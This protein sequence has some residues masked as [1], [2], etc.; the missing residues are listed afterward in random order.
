[1]RRD[2][3]HGYI[4][5][6]PE[7]QRYKSSTTK[8]MGPLHPLPIPDGRG[9]SVAMDFVGPLPEDEG[10]NCILTIT[11][12]LHSDIRIVP[13]RTDLTAPQLAELFFE[14]WYCE[15]GLPADIVCDRDRLFVS[16]FWRHLTKLLGIKI[17]MSTAYHLQTDGSS[18][19]SNKTVIQA[20]RFHVDRSQ[21]NWVR[22][23]RRVRFDIMN[24]VN[25]STGFLPFQLRMGHSPRVVPPLIP[26]VEPPQSE[27]DVARK[28]I[29]RLAVDTA[30]AQD[31]MWQAKVQQAV[32]ANKSRSDDCNFQIGDKVLVC[33]KD[34]QRM[35]KRR[36]H[37][38]V[39]K[40]MPRYDGPFVVTAVHPES[41]NVTV[42]RPNA[43][44]A[45]SQYHTSKLMFFSE[46]DA[47]LF[48]SREF[49]ELGPVFAPDTGLQEH[50]VEKIVDARR[51]GKGW[52]YLV[53]FRGYGPEHDEWKSGQELSN[54]Q[55]L[56]VWLAGEGK[57]ST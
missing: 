19:R 15:N 46:N 21:K 12:R 41:S 26:A 14:H 29:E 31:N 37:K 27:E 4:P 32:Q 13:T 52:Q 48:P 47:R 43:P 34:T 23:L 50:Y 33:T 3:E 20:L 2:L 9:E 53:R 5:A 11:D 22:A 36:G 6:C 39:A 49:D 10:Y 16:R 54:N 24:T 7:C 51:R 25:K 28:I 44:E 17:K 40:L 35:F 56:D 42:F 8:P 30:T 1:M 57:G 38:R 55:V 18:K 45:Y